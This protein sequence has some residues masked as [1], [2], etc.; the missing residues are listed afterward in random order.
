M[1]RVHK[2]RRLGHGPA[3]RSRL[4]LAV[5]DASLPVRTLRM[6]YVDNMREVYTR[7]WCLSK[8]VRAPFELCWR[9]QQGYLFDPHWD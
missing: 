3:A 7:R 5:S 2:N 4:H 1:A 9:D 6:I 8:G